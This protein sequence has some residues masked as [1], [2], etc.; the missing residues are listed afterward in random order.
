MYLIK[1]TENPTRLKH[2]RWTLNFKN[3]ILK[4]PTFFNMFHNVLVVVAADS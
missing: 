2:K 1:F 4:S 3:N